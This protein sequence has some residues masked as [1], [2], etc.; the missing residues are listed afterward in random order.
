MELPGQSHCVDR[1]SSC[2]TQTPHLSDGAQ[3]QDPLDTSLSKVHWSESNFI[4]AEF[5]SQPFFHTLHLQFL[6]RDLTGFKPNTTAQKAID[7]LHMHKATLQ[8]PNNAFQSIA[9]AEQ[10]L[11]RQ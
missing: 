3:K 1:S 7:S 6:G 8:H 4:M 9:S 10:T 5:S 11:H 2:T